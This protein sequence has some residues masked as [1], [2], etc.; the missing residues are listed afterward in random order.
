MHKICRF[1]LMFGVKFGLTD[2]LCVKH[3]TL[4]NSELANSWLNMGTSVLA[5]MIRRPRRSWA[6]QI[7]IPTK[8]E[9]TINAVH[10][11]EDIMLSVHFQGRVFGLLKQIIFNI[12]SAFGSNLYLKVQR[13]DNLW[14]FRRLSVG[15]LQLNPANI[16]HFCK[17]GE[18]HPFL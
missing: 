3:L 13:E 15:R 2:L 8:S 1:T 17:P 18:D 10:V 7:R 6:R 16:K 11:A 4:W 5:R 9:D 12:F 14:I